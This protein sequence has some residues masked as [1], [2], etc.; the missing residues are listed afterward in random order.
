MVIAAQ[1]YSGSGLIDD[2]TEL[3]IMYGNRVVGGIFETVYVD[4]EQYGTFEFYLYST[5]YH[6]ND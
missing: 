4:D 2:L 6:F 3:Q 5:E 1:L